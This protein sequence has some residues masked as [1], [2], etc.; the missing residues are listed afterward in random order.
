MRFLIAFAVVGLALLSSAPAQTVTW[1]K[2]QPAGIGFTVDMPAAPVLKTDQAGGRPAY[3]ATVAFD[4]AQAGADKVFL[5][6][7]QAARKDMG[8]DTAP[9]LDRVVAAM[10]EANKVLSDKKETLAGFPARR[11]AFQDSD[12]DNYEVRA[13]ITPDYFIQAMFLGPVGDPLGKRFLDSFTI[14]TED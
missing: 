10:T 1:Q 11:F 2:Y 13:V 5:V 7:Y 3:S 6:K 4:K 9:I 12:K 14:E 8:P